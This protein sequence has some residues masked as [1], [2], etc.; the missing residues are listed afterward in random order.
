MTAESW[1]FANWDIGEPTNAGGN[2]D[3]LVMWTGG[4]WHDLLADYGIHYI[5][6]WPAGPTTESDCNANTIPDS[7]EIAN[8]GDCNN[9]GLLDACE[10]FDQT[11][12]DCNN[13]SVPDSCDIESGTARDCNL[14]GV[15]D[16]C[17]I[18]AGALDEN[19]D[20]R[21]D[22]CNYA[23][24]DFDLDNAVSSSDLGF[25]LIFFGEIDPPFG[26]LN[27]SGVCDAEDLGQL[28]GNYGILP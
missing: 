24:G 4:K 28:L 27:G 26:D 25:L 18:A 8:G 2:E 1:S 3:H 17:D 6:E 20:G 11:T 13:N 9:N 10:T 7:C 5:V 21:I 14:N 23:L 22:A 12:P 16:S 19:S 15:P